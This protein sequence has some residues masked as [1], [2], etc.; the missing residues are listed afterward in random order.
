[1]ITANISNICV[2]SIK[3]LNICIASIKGLF[4]WGRDKK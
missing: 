1:M 4:S 2:A 3:V